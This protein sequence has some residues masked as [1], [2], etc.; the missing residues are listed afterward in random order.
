MADTI[1]DITF[2]GVTVHETTDGAHTGT[3]TGTLKVDYTTNTA[4]LAS[5]TPALTFSGTG[6][7]GTQSY[8]TLLSS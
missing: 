7:G 8:T 5:G 1:V 3:L 6:I 2:T 4:I